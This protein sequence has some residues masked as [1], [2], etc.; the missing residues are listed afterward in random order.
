MSAEF[1]DAKTASILFEHWIG[2]YPFP[3]TKFQFEGKLYNT[4]R[5]AVSSTYNRVA[6]VLEEDVVTPGGHDE[7]LDKELIRILESA[8]VIA[9]T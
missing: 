6:V 3:G 4:V 2:S 7:A 1:V 8:S 5:V 9:H